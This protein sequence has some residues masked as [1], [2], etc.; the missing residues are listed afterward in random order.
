MNLENPRIVGHLGD[1]IY[2][3]SAC[4]LLPSEQLGVFFS[5]NTSTGMSA[6]FS[7]LKDF[8][9]RFAREIKGSVLAAR[10]PLPSAAYLSQFAGSFATNRRS[11]SDLTKLV[12]LGMRVGVRLGERAGEL[13]IY[14]FFQGNYIPHVEVEPDIFQEVDGTGRWIF[15]RDAQKRVVGVFGNGFPVMVFVRSPWYEAVALHLVIV[16]LFLLCLLVGIFAR[17]TGIWGWLFAKSRLAG[18]ERVAGLFGSGVL[19]GYL[20]FFL[21]AIATFSDDFIFEMP[22]RWVFV[23]PYLPMLLNVGMVYYAV[24][25]WRRGLFGWMGRGFYTLFALSAVAFGWFLA[26]WKI[27]A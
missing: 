18:E 26:Y 9:R 19:F 17:P 12:S 13:Q 24:S 7:L 14:D 10:R 4:F 8:L 27:L 21:A 25:A 16:V 5:T 22:R 23:L 3:H 20:V 2:F 1:T 11:E 6:S 15:L